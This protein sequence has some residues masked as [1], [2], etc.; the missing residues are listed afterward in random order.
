MIQRNRRVVNCIPEMKKEVC[1][2]EN[3]IFDQFGK[4]FLQ[5]IEN[6]SR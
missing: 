1:K 5:Y 2:I 3:L 4:K 6:A